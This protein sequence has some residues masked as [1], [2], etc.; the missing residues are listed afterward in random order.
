MD[1]ENNPLISVVIPVYNSSGTLKKCLESV[2]S[3]TGVGFEV[4]VVDD[5]S[6]D[7]TA[8]ILDEFRCRTPRI[9]PLRR[10]HVGIVP[11]LNAGLAAA[12]GSFIARMDAD[13]V[14]CAGRLKAQ[15][16]HLLRH[17]ETGLVGGRVL[18]GGD[19]RRQ[20]GYAVHVDWLNKIR[21]P[22]EIQ[23]N[24]FVESPFAHPSVMFRKRLIDQHGSYRDGPFPEDYE[25]W[26]RWFDAG[27]EMA[28]I[29]APVVVWNDPPQR[30]SRTDE[31]YS[32]DAFYRC[33]AE[34]LARWLKKTA[35]VDRPRIAVWGAGRTTRKRAEY[36]CDFGVEISAYIDIDPRKV[37][38]TIH[39]RPVLGE[40]ELARLD[41]DFL[42]PFVGSRGA[43]KDIRKQL[44]AQGF[45]EGRHYIMAA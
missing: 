31:R 30:L 44:M 2:L 16:D 9:R 3:Q 40:D 22:E 20:R 39:G 7:S 10:S 29:D 36:L 8:E 23:L 13:D 15:R 38:Q 4:V 27:V 11:A 42:V 18:Y 1:A 32:V 12:R 41:M 21:T 37:G 35:E 25:L 24:R 45:I 14:C 43:R 33:K 19:R 28:K 5:G 17:P 34:Y 6:T 26:L